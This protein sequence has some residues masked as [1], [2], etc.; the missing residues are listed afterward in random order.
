MAEMS[1]FAD[2]S[3]DE[4]EN[5]ETDQ[6]DIF[7]TTTFRNTT[8]LD[9]E[10]RPPYAMTKLERLRKFPKQMT[11]PTSYR[12]NSPKE[13]LCLEFVE[14]FRGQ[15]VQL[16]P[17]RPPLM[18]SPLNECGIKKFVCTFARPTELS[19]GELYDYDTCAKY[20]ANYITYQPLEDPEKLPSVVVS[21][22]TT[23]AWQAGDCF[24]I[25]LLLLSLLLG[26]GYNAY[27]VIGYASKEVV[28]NDQSR[29][30]CPDVVPNEADSEKAGK[31]EKPPSTKY[32]LRKRPE[33][34]STFQKTLEEKRRQ[35]REEDNKQDEAE[36]MDANQEAAPDPAY[37]KPLHCWILV[38]PGKREVQGNIFIEPST[39][40]A[41]PVK[42]ASQYLE[43]ESLFNNVN[44]WINMQDGLPVTEMSFDLKDSSNWEYIFLSD[45]YVDPEDVEGQ[46]RKASENVTSE[47]GEMGD[48]ILDL[49]SSW[50]QRLELSRQQFENRYPGLQKVIQ[51]KDATLEL[52][53]AYSE[54]DLKI[55]RLHLME[56]GE[57]VEVHTFFAFRT[58]KLRRRSEYAATTGRPWKVSHEWFDE[59]RRREQ[60][61]LEALREYIVEEG[62]CA[63]MRF[64][65]KAR[66][67]GLARRLEL[68]HE[69]AVGGGEGG[70]APMP[71]KVIEYFEGREDRLVYRSATYNPP[72]ASVTITVS[73][74][75]PTRSATASEEKP[76]PRKMT[77]KFDRNP[78]V[79]A[80]QDVAKRTF[81]QPGTPEGQIRLIYHYA[82]GKITRPS[83]M[84]SK[85]NPVMVEQVDPFAKNPKSSAL[86]EEMRAL[87][88]KEKD[89]L[90]AIRESEREAREI[91]A[92]R[93]REEADV[94]HITV[95]Y[96]TLRNK[97][98]ED[99]QAEAR[100]KQEE[101][102]RSQK[103]KDYLAPYL[104]QVLRVHTRGAMVAQGAA[105]VR[106]QQLTK[107]EAQKVKEI[108]LRDLKD[109]LIQ[110]AHIMQNRLD[111]ERE[112][113]ARKQSNFQK[114]QE[115]LDGV[116]EQEEYTTFCENAMWRI[117]I[118]EKR[119]ER[120]QE[121]SLHKYAALE[122][123]LRRDPRL[124]TLA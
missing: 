89:C 17:E 16:F 34:Q 5:S 65:C 10:G 46:E 51:Y 19:Y 25:S 3:D 72:E 15:Y 86:A 119:L 56:Y 82:D 58:D 61:A 44:Y 38:Q 2:L 21:P 26:S 106:P 121:Q 109:R 75:T 78:E 90:A 112:K 95:V 120:H 96:D 37:R 107:D 84:Y 35:E 93:D 79:P 108:C 111:E 36:D 12:S 77:E 91:L 88:L 62:R 43:V 23:L 64:Y 14:H 40:D 39:G 114:N 71:R 68:F 54:K 85:G 48:Q 41:I 98:K 115:Q 110:R 42:Q 27:C 97:P 45:T 73:G 99:E 52:F 116:K 22:T 20:V 50:V 33:L 60:S 13:D 7:A 8:E 94:G 122:Q 67:D 4:A 76:N 117:H 101:L 118:L 123:K 18:L 59:G 124:S 6:G 30:K 69:G 47:C 63:E 57:E 74:S 32:V 100:R 104:E 49:P 70:P 11:F 83:R 102:L 55:K 105:S 80:D 81:Y 1:H 66:L 24:D 9:W 113:L 29:R 28:L 87:F 103:K 31:A 92:Q 53:S